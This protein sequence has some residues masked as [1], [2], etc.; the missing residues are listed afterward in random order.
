MGFYGYHG[1]ACRCVRRRTV[2]ESDHAK[3][4]GRETTF[5]AEVAA[6][7]RPPFAICTFRARHENRSK[8]IKKQVHNVRKPYV[9]PHGRQ[10][11]S[12]VLL[13]VAGVEPACTTP[14][15]AR[16][17]AGGPSVEAVDGE[18]T[19]PGRRKPSKTFAP[20]STASL[21]RLHVLGTRTR[22]GTRWL[23]MLTHRRRQRACCGSAR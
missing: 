5:G 9:H 4:H 10:F 1:F 7:L 13:A 8:T 3:D 23:R 2:A 19:V 21:Q 11:S 17:H 15:V 22:D 18:S 14:T 16:L 12:V 20:M 6:Q